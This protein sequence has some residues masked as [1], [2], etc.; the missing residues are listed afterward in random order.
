[1][2]R[3]FDWIL[4]AIFAWCWLPGLLPLHLR[5]WLPVASAVVSR[6]EIIERKPFAGGQE[7]GSVGV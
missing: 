5:S 7:F 2:C 3:R 6:I 1:M 4:I